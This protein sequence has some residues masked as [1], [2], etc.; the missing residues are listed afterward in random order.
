LKFNLK[1]RPTHHGFAFGEDSERDF[2][3]ARDCIVW[4][5]A[6]EKELRKKLVYPT[7]VKTIAEYDLITE[8]LG[9]VV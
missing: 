5:E 4:F 3:Y 7:N 9:E 6:F 2:A 8:I 1:N